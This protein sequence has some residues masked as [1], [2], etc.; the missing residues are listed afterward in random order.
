[1]AN[2]LERLTTAEFCERILQLMEAGQPLPSWFLNEIR[3][4]LEEGDRDKFF[5]SFLPLPVRDLMEKAAQADRLRLAL[6][7]VEMS[8]MTACL[9]KRPDIATCA[10]LALREKDATRTDSVRSEEPKP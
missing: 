5:V 6:E 4:R 2:P 8:A 3:R 1:M 10:R 7:D 9:P